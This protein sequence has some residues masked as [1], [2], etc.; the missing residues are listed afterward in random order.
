MIPAKILS[1]PR[2]VCKK[3]VTKPDREPDNIAIKIPKIGCPEIV[4][5]ADTAVP[6]V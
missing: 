3:A 1:I 2:V 4:K 6:K 5:T